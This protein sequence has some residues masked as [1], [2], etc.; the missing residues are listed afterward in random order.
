MGAALLLAAAG[1]LLVA[2]CGDDDVSTPCEYCEHW[3]LVLDGLARFP[4]YSPDPA[5]SDRIA[6]SSR[7]P[8]P[9]GVTEEDRFEHIWV[10]DN[11]ELFRITDSEFN[12]FDPAWSPDGSAIAFT[13]EMDGRLDVWTVGVADLSSPGVP[14]RLTWPGNVDVGGS[15]VSWMEDTEGIW[16]VFFSDEDVYSI[17]VSGGTPRKLIPDPMDVGGTCGFESYPDFQPCVGPNGQVAF[18]S[19]GRVRTGNLEVSGFFV[20]TSGET[21][22]VTDAVI[23]LDDCCTGFHI[24]HTFDFLPVKPDLGSYTLSVESPEHCDRRSRYPVILPNQNTSVRFNFIAEKG[25]LWIWVNEANCD[26][27]DIFEGDTTWVAHLG[28]GFPWPDST[29]VPC[30]AEGD[31]I[32]HIVWNIYTIKDTA[33]AITAGQLDTLR[34]IKPA[35]GSVDRR[36]TGLSPGSSRVALRARPVQTG[37]EEIWIT[38]LVNRKMTGFWSL[39]SEFEQPC[40]SPDGQYVAF[41]AHDG[42]RNLWGIRVADVGGSSIWSIPLPGSSGAASCSRSAYH[43]SWNSAGDR[44][45]VAMGECGGFEAPQ[46]LRIWWVDPRPFLGK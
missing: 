29:L 32:I 1:M 41:V 4:A 44:L 35:K 8:D 34:V 26:A 37:H 28:E 17:P 42:F 6:F 38:D 39:D 18:T 45:A 13:R 36:L 23:Y 10:L 20:E 3:S 11:T 14:V 15:Q 46:E 30:L 22:D 27:Y 9:E 43:L 31:H 2:G 7:L 24:P 40:W 16:I 19:I 12:D 21:L 25:D 33:F 5:H